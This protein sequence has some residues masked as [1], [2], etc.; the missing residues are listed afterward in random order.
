MP[1]R[2]AAALLQAYTTTHRWFRNHSHHIRIQIL[3]NENPKAL[4][5]HF[6]SLL[7]K[8]QMV[9]PFNKRTNKA[10]RAIQTFK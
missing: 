10:E 4:Q 7:I 6:D 1:S 9:T 2:T 3:D 8:W 5:D